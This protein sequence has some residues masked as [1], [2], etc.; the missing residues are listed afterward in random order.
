MTTTTIALP[1]VADDLVRLKELREQ[2]KTIEAEISELNPGVLDTMRAIGLEVQLPMIGQRA[3]LVEPTLLVIPDMTAYYKAATRT[4]YHATTSRVTNG[5]ALR[6]LFDLRLLGRAQDKVET[7]PGTS[8]V[9]FDP[10]R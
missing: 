3:N 10:A 1:S 2:K 4:V 7:V 6:D 8:Y 9:R 5:S